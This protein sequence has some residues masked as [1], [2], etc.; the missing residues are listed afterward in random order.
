MQPPGLGEHAQVAVFSLLVPPQMNKY[1]NLYPDFTLTIDNCDVEPINR[2]VAIQGHGHMLVFDAGTPDRLFAMSEHVPQL[3]AIDEELLWTTTTKEWL[4]PQLYRVYEEMDRPGTWDAIDP[5]IVELGDKKYNAIRFIDGDKRFIEIEPRSPLGSKAPSAFKVIRQATEPLK[6]C[7][8]EESLFQEAAK[9]VKAATGYDRVMVYRFD[10]DLH[11]HVVGEAKEDHL[12][13]FLDLHYPA[14]DIPKIAR[15]LFLLNRSRIITDINLPYHWLKFNPGLG[16]TP[17]KLDLTHSQLRATS[18]VHIEYLQNMGV[19]ASLSLAIIHEGEL[20]GLF[21]CHHYSPYFVSFELRKTLEIISN[22]FM[23]RLV[24]VERQTL[25]RLQSQYLSLEYE[26]LSSV[27][28]QKD[29]AVQLIDRKPDY[30][31]MCHSDGMAFVTSEF[32]NYSYGFSP[33]PEELNN[34]ATW[35]Q[36]NDKSFFDTHN[37]MQDLPDNI[38]PSKE[39]GGMLAINISN[40]SHNYILWFR[41]PVRQVTT[42]GGNPEQ[43]HLVKPAQDDEPARLSPRKSFEKWQVEIKER[44]LPW[45]QTALTMAARVREWM[46]KKEFER[47]ASKVDQ[48]RREFEHLTYIA[49]HD[50]QEPLITVMSYLEALQDEFAEEFQDEDAKY[51]LERAMAGSQRMRNLIADMLDYSRIGKERTWDWVDLNEVISHI[52]DDLEETLEENDATIKIARLP[53]MKGSESELRQLFQNLISNAIKYR[54]HDKAPIVEVSAEYR[55]PNWCFSVTDNGIGIEE[56]DYDSVFL[57]FKRLHPKDVYDGTGIGLA[58]CK[59]IVDNYDGHIS[60]RSTF[61]EGSTF[62]VTI[63]ESYIDNRT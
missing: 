40:Q 45:E 54:H 10:E 6:R 8:D 37:L 16:S 13:P 12:E 4:P 29:I 1:P 25:D 7:H 51:Y 58:N 49:S 34:I 52:Q 3:L 41:K 9:Q 31:E 55:S 2:P 24:E 30:T 32:G 47:T 5:V 11:G 57:L 60:V 42:W 26:L 28:T 61:G 53:M 20:W 18:P 36:E 43:A 27:N 33:E 56:K 17:P 46:L 59:K 22:M 63:H 14:S 48:M 21:A 19:G 62:Y 44:S 50:M 38:R 23:Q 39:M 15:D 35:L